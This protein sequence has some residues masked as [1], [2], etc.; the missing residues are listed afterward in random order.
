[1]GFQLNAD[2]ATKGK[3]FAWNR[4]REQLM[5]FNGILLSIMSQKDIIDMY[6]MIDEKLKGTGN[7]GGGSPLDECRTFLEG[8]G[9]KIKPKIGRPEKIH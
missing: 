3:V 7:S 8:D 4:Y 1:M 9:P 2:L 5:E 6:W